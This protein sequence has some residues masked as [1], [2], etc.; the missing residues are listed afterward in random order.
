[1]LPGLVT[2]DE[3]MSGQITHA[4]GMTVPLSQQSY[5]WPARHWASSADGWQLPRFGQRFRL[6]AGFDVSPYPFEVQVI[7]N[8]LKKYG[9]IVEDNGAPW[10]LSGVQD[11]RWND[12]NLQTIRQIMGS[13]ME[14]VDDSSLMVEPNS[15]VAAG[16]G[17]AL[18]GVYINQREVGAGAPVTAEVILSAPAP[19]GGA[20]VSLSIST[21]GVLGI[22]AASNPARTSSN[23]A[24]DGASSVCTPRQAASSPAHTEGTRA[25]IDCFSSTAARSS[26]VGSPSHARASAESGSAGATGWRSAVTPPPKACR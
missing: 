14:A 3:V 22:P 15:Q 6:K 16:S 10:F 7:L 18:D 20:T 9:A 26:S 11:P 8:A 1:M 12:S 24:S 5:I 19:G 25:S 2:Y 21:P 23:S 13:N 4:I 17:L